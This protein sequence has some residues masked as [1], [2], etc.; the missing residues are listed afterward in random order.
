MNSDFLTKSLEES[1][2]EIVKGDVAHYIPE[3]QKADRND[4]GITIMDIYG[5]VYSSGDSDKKFTIQSVSKPVALILA[6]MDVGEEVVFSKVGKEPTGDP[7]N[8]MVRL[9]TYTLNK[10]LNPMINAGAIAIDSLIKGDS[11]VHKLERLL[12]FMR[13]LTGNDSIDYSR[14]VYRSEK[15]TSD[16]NRAL[17]YFLKDIGTFDSPVDEVLDLYFM[18]CSILV[19]ASDLAKIGLILANDGVDPVTGEFKFPKRFAK[20]AKAFMVTCGMYD[21]SGTFA[22]NVGI[23][24][25]SGVGGG[26]MSAVTGKYGIGVYGPSIDSKGNSVAGM[27]LLR[28]I[29]ENCNLTIF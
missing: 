4:L 2:K 22:I 10:P 7:F 15:S 1:R 16:R 21:E 25:K 5:N 27:E 13:D 17:A 6:L 28:I 24:S 8:S 23:P 14:E 3:L 26:I 18:Q 9:E 29:S 20:I 11:P 19:T 12:T